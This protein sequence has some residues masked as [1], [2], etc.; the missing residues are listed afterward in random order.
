MLSAYAKNFN[1]LL[2]FSENV[3]IAINGT[4][5]ATKTALKSYGRKWRFCHIDV[6]F[7]ACL[8]NNRVYSKYPT[9]YP[10][11]YQAMSTF[12][13]LATYLIATFMPLTFH[14]AALQFLHELPKCTLAIDMQDLATFLLF[15]TCRFVQQF[16]S[17]VNASLK[18][19]PFCF[20]IIYS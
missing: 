15:S 2:P 6:Y 8:L 3:C 1:V 14:S 10:W 12:Y 19:T 9:T 16:R 13:E 5:S 20:H 18:P 17:L 7:T 4:H 11:T